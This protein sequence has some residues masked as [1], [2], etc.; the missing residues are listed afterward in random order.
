MTRRQSKLK[1]EGV[2]KLRKCFQYVHQTRMLLC[3]TLSVPQKKKD[4]VLPYCYI[5]FAR[6]K[7]FNKMLPI[8][9]MMK[10]KN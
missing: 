9:T 5:K 10:I 6:L 2:D 8:K 3:R 7:V 4:T 1:D